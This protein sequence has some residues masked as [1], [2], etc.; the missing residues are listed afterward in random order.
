MCVSQ[1]HVWSIEFLS[2]NHIF[3]VNITGDSINL[4]DKLFRLINYCYYKNGVSWISKM[5]PKISVLGYKARSII[6]INKKSCFKMILTRFC[7]LLF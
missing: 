1:K 7:V 3:K 2:S 5:T 6:I 4:N